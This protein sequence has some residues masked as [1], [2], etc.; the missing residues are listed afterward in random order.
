M[1]AKAAQAE[2]KPQQ[3]AVSSG[4]LSSIDQKL[5]SQGVEPAKFEQ[6]PPASEIK[7]GATKSESA[8]KIELEPKLALDKGPLFLSP[9]EAPEK[10]SSAQEPVTQDKKPA[11]PGKPQEPSV[12]EVPKTLVKGPIQTQAAPPATKPAEQKK[13]ASSGQEEENKGALDQLR[14]ELDAIGRVLNPFRW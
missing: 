3:S 10:S 14:Q 7:G 9:A 6:P 13:P 8:K 5:K 2:A 1:R 4:L 11:T 12:R